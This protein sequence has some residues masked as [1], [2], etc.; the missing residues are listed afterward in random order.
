MIGIGRQ[1]AID[2]G[3]AL[4]AGLES[5]V[6]EQLVTL[7]TVPGKKEEQEHGRGKYG[8]DDSGHGSD[9]EAPI[10]TAPLWICE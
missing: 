1:R 3:P 10:L 4:H 5:A 9:P 6:D 7:C 2:G 8:S